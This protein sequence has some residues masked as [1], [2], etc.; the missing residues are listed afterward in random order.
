VGPYEE[1]HVTHSALG[2]WLA[3]EGWVVAGP[4]WESYVTDPGANPD[5]KTWRTEIY[6]PVRRP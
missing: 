2:G 4:P 6:M 3:Q 1:L 5:P